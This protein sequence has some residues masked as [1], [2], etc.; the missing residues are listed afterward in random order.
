[1]GSGAVQ[2][3][4]RLERFVSASLRRGYMGTEGGTIGDYPNGT[5]GGERQNETKPI[6][7]KKQ[8]L[9]ITNLWEQS[10]A[11]LGIIQ[12]AHLAQMTAIRKPN[13][14]CRNQ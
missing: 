11:L 4:G 5:P 8:K 7:Q 3:S 10:V 9:A 12:R 14:L 13:K 2:L 6:N 1:M